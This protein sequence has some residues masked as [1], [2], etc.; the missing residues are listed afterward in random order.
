MSPAMTQ[1]LRNEARENR[2]FVWRA[3]NYLAREHGITQFIDVGSGLPTV[4]ST[5]QVAQEINP[6]ARVVY[7][8]NDPIVLSH[9]RALL[10]KNGN[11]RIVSADV[12]D[13]D[14]ILNAEATR[15]LIDFSKP[16][17]AVGRHRR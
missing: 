9:G 5:H 2:R 16:V 14:S 11:T 3:V 13:P 12:R 4:R 7:V 1:L 10:A 8:D 6:D 15:Q 17:A